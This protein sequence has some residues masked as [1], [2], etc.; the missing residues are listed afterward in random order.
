MAATKTKAKPK[1]TKKVVKA[2]GVASSK[3]KKNGNEIEQAM[4][5]A[6]EQCMKDK[7]TDPSEI[8]NKM[9]EARKQVRARTSK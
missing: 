8:R 6:A 4:T 5:A 9:L 7:V 1:R 3:A 2:V